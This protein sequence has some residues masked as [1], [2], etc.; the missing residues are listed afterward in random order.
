MRF[1]A[2]AYEELF[3][4]VEK[5]VDNFPREI[6]PEDQ[7]VEVP[8]EEKEDKEA[9]EDGIRTDGKPDTE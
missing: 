7:M 4:R 3:P 8:K 6:D 5:P 9:D 2:K 1:N